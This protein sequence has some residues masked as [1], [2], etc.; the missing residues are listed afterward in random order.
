MRLILAVAATLFLA[1]APGQ[2]QGTSACAGFKWSIAREQSAFA[3]PDLPVVDAGES[4]SGIGHAATVMLK[5]QKETSFIKPPGRKPK[6]DPAFAAVLN[7]APVVSAGRYQV[8]L[9]DEAWID[10]LQNGK[11]VRSSGFSGQPDCPGVRKSVRFA[12][13][14]GPAMLQVSGSAADSIK[15][16]VLPAE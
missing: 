5:P 3:A 2:A 15:I 16:D 11:E 6:V 9:S 7:L 13:Q 4:L 12:L 1:P 14:P 10:V 8:T